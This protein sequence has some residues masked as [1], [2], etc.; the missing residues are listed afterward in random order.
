LFKS[1]INELLEFI[2][3]SLIKALTVS[4]KGILKEEVTDEER[5]LSTELLI[6]LKK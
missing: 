3:L 4:L 6:E 5:E 2:T 1:F